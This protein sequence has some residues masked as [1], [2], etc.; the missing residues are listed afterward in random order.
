[1]PHLGRIE[2]PD[3]GH[4]GDLCKAHGSFRCE[5]VREH[6]NGQPSALTAADH[7]GIPLL[8]ALDKHLVAALRSGAI[9]LLRAEFLRADGSEAMLPE[10]LR[11]QELEWMETEIGIR[12]FL[13][14]E[15]AV[16]ALRS[17]SRE[18]AGLTYGWASPDH[19]DVTG[20]YLANVRRF[21]RHPL[22]EH[23]TALFWDFS[24]LPQKPR[25]ATEDKL[26]YQALDVMGDVYASALGTIVIRHRS[27]PARPAELDG[28][29]VILVE[30]G[31]G[32]DGAGAEAELTIVVQL[33]GE[34]K[35]VTFVMDPVN[36]TAEVVADEM[37]EELELDRWD[38]TREDIISQVN[39]LLDERR[40]PAGAEAK[41]R[42]ALGAFE[43]P[44][45]EEGRRRVRFPTH[46][47]AEEAVAAAAA[48]GAL[49]GAIA[50]FLFYN[51]RPYH[52]RGWTTFESAVSTEALAQLAYYPGLGK[53]LEELPPKVIEIDGEGP[54][55]AEMED[56]AD[57][58]MGPRNERVIA[59]IEA[60]SFTG[61]GDKPV[62]VQ[63]YRDY[64]IKVNNAMVRSGEVQKG[65]YEGE[66]NAAGEREGRGV[67]RFA[68]GNVYEGEF[69]AGK[70]EGRGVFRYTDGDVV[71]GFCKQGGPVGEGV[72]WMADGQRA[73]QLR[74]GKAV[75]WIS[76]EE[77]RQTA[78]RLGLPL[79]SPLPG[80]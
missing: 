46:A 26:F 53:L 17:L 36:D 59:A 54:R 8:A 57:E 69:K 77:A 31:G 4:A 28:E 65:E 39:R 22:G 48:A 5:H 67:Y 58:G 73:A 50:V 74:D 9:K 15:E 45:Y 38:G 80:A 43:N 2:W 7:K 19:P 62:V 66:Y 24:S 56:R 1:M 51:G 71:S 75:E 44:R 10:L 29:V 61:K 32:L 25:T 23:V 64:A 21:L 35:T 55:V 11:R 27:V 34:A 78:E 14:P 68:N 49:P 70:I 60:A 40:T 12:I 41:L 79:P 30:K 37:V 33:N 20:E 18:V 76:L 13:S 6:I 52:A 47:A 16:A 72:K 3:I 63:L 42:R